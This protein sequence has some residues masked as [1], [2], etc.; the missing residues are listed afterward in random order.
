MRRLAAHTRV[1]QLSHH[2]YPKHEAPLLR[3]EGVGGGGG[4]N[5]AARVLREDVHGRMN[6]QKKTFSLIT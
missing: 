3:G 2:L 6:H 5:V 4:T 1:L